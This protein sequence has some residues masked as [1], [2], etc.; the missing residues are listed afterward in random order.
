MR[1]MD[2][3]DNHLGIDL[4][5][6]S[7]AE[8]EAHIRDYMGGESDVDYAKLAETMRPIFRLDRNDR[9]GLLHAWGAFFCI[10]CGSGYLPCH[11]WNDE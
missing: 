10:Y 9:E 8:I 4:A 6:L 1:D 3:N 5:A 11:C 7:N 2:A